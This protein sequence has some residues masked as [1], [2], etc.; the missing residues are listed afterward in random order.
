M[1]K[2]NRIKPLAFAKFQAYL[3]LLIGLV[4]GLVYAFGGLI[5]DTLVTLNMIS[6]NETP[7][8]SYGTI[9]AF[10]ALF[11]MPIIFAGFAAI[12]GFVE[13]LLYNF[14]FTRFAHIPNDF[15]EDN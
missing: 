8:L 5:I 11:G 13:S 7:G 1:K 2:I 14:F 6:T 9:L 4:F 10:G 15:I 12:T 3:G